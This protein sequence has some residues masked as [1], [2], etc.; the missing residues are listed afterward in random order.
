[1]IPVCPKCDVALIIMIYDEVEVDYCPRCLGLW[2]DA[3]ELD[4]LCRRVGMGPCDPLGAFVDIIEGSA[5]VRD[6]VPCPRCDTPLTEIAG[7]FGEQEILLDRC[8]S[9]HGIW[10]DAQEL[11][12][13]MSKLAGKNNHSAI[14][15]ELDRIVGGP[16]DVNHNRTGA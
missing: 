2:L 7:K 16:P 10:F 8:S 11:P 14:V 5:A 6:E 12:L 3:G 1:M 13:L 4:E 9:G 15:A